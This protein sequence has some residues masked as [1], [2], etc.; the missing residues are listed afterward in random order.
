MGIQFPTCCLSNL[1]I[2]DG[3][4]A[5]QVL[6]VPGQN[7]PRKEE[8]FPTL[9]AYDGSAHGPTSFYR[10]LLW[11]IFGTHN[12]YGGLWP[13]ATNDPAPHVA[14]PHLFKRLLFDHTTHTQE[15][16]PEGDNPPY[17][18]L[19]PMELGSFLKRRAYFHY[20]VKVNG[21]T[22][23]AF[24]P[25]P[26]YSTLI[27]QDVW[28]HLC[29]G[30]A[31]MLEGAEKYLEELPSNNRDALRRRSELEESDNPFCKAGRIL[32]LSALDH[33]FQKAPREDVRAAVDA[34]VG[35]YCINDC[36]DLARRFWTPM[37]GAGSQDVNTTSQARFAQVT[38]WAIQAIRAQIK[39]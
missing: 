31:S 32:G 14:A 1:P 10:P 28:G 18:P 17:E 33:Y 30:S 5:V 15:Q 21:F 4:K 16:I 8:H 11:P 19:K 37:T 7:H 35:L 34:L 25:V 24:G 3:E 6:L 20:P 38:I 2:L 36:L 26:L 39:D 27:R 12:G 13:A 9:G 29:L 22:A 23:S